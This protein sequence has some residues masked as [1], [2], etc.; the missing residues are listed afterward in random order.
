MNHRPSVTKLQKY[1]KVFEGSLKGHDAPLI[2]CFKDAKRYL[3]TAPQHHLHLLSRFGRPLASVA[4][5][6]ASTWE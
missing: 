5:A 3:F 1:F 4:Q 6:F 2:K